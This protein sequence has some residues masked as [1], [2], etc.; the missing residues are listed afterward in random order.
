MNFPGIF[1]IFGVFFVPLNIFWAFPGFLL[2][3]KN[4]SKKK[5]IYRIGPSQRPD[6]TRSALSARP[7]LGP[8]KA[9]REAWPH[10]Q[11]AASG[12]WPWRACAPGPPCPA[13][14]KG[15]ARGRPRARTLA[16]P[17][18]FAA[19]RRREPTGTPPPMRRSR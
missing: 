9:H 7:D 19:S 4:I 10:G 13:P 8:A 16:P 1:V 5:K 12:R 14:Y 2:A 11:G 18:R 17:C 6:P 3:L 15:S